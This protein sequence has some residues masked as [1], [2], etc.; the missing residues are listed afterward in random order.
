MQ[1]YS[2]W[3]LRLDSD[4]TSAHPRILGII[5]VYALLAAKQHYNQLSDR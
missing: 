5:A 1:I 4:M 2:F 3:E